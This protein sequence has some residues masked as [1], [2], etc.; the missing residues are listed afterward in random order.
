MELEAT[1]K[2]RPAKISDLKRQIGDVKLEKKKY[3]A[4]LSL[5]RKE[6][7]RL[8]QAYQEGQSIPELIIQAKE[9]LL[10][11]SALVDAAAKKEKLKAEQDAA[12]NLD[13]NT[14]DLA[15]PP[16]APEAP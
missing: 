6:L 16:T 11:N 14:G 10:Q 8:Q 1:I 3:Q 7:A 13:G 12:V 9:L 4:Q 2:D 15:V 5:I